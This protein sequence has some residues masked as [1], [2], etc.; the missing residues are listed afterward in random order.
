MAVRSTPG[1]FT[2]LL[3]FH[4]SR[5]SDVHGQSPVAAKIGPYSL[6]VP[7][8]E[9]CYPRRFGAERTGEPVM[10][11]R[12]RMNRFAV[13][14]KPRIRCA[15][16]SGTAVFFGSDRG[17]GAAASFRLRHAGR[18]SCWAFTPMLLWT[19]TCISCGGFRRRVVAGGRWRH[20]AKKV[21]TA[22]F[23]SEPGAVTLRKGRHIWLFFEEA[24]PQPRPRNL[25]SHC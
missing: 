12:A 1:R 11:R 19:K 8:R 23:G 16:L 18:D 17:S 20:F 3:V 9:D 22:R 13:C 7:W 2:G 5:T 14:E 4:R 25:G 21:P 10:R 15:G 6:I 24:I